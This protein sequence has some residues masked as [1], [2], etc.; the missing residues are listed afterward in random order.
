ME[1]NKCDKKKVILWMRYYLLLYSKPN[2]S[3]HA[4]PITTTTL[5]CCIS[6]RVLVLVIYMSSRLKL[7]VDTELICV[8]S[9]YR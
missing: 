7:Q 9:V 4:R 6:A 2:Q 8:A 1:L 5:Y 3:N